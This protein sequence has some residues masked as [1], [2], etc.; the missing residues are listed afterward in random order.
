MYFKEVFKMSRIGKKPIPIPQGVEVKIEKGIVKVKG[1]KGELSFSP[2]PEMKIE[3]KDNEIIV[4]RPS[5]KKFFKA[6]H[7][8]TRQIIANM[9]KGVSEGFVKELEIVG[10]GYRAKKE[11]NRI[12]LHVGFSTPVYYSPPP[13][14]KVELDGETKIRVSGI[15]KQKVGQV[16]A[17]IRAIKPPEPYKGKGIRYVGEYVRKKAGKAG[18]KAQA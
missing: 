17:E 9:V 18:V 11:G 6:L 7:G 16:A 5:D 4:R 1:P 10:T 2:H 15:D 14:V 12:A 8:T 3:L 13:D